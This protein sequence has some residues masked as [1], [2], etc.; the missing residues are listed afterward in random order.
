MEAS[1]KEPN[2]A[3]A[4]GKLKKELFRIKKVCDDA[5]QDPK[6]SGRSDKVMLV[7]QR[8]VASN[9]KPKWLKVN[10]INVSAYLVVDKTGD[11]P[12]RIETP[13]LFWM[14]VMVAKTQAMK[15][16]VTKKKILL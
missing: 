7:S 12:Q 10:P 9:S 2:D 11:S 6:P 15:G 3:L 8:N 13:Q 14:R 4:L 16:M 5:T 1:S